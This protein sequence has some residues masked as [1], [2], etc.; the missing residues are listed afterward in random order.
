MPVHAQTL[1]NGDPIGNNYLKK[2]KCYL[3]HQRTKLLMC[4]Q[5]NYILKPVFQTFR[6][7]RCPV[8]PLNWHM[9]WKERARV[10]CKQLE[11]DCTNRNNCE[12]VLNSGLVIHVRT[13]GLI[14]LFSSFIGKSSF[15]IM[16][17]GECVI[18]L[19]IIKLIYWVNLNLYTLN[20]H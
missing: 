9:Y 18:I 10:P 8:V 11:I 7:R 17:I 19:S 16:I 5:S 14:V 2:S 15:K 1:L 4:R 20:L 6:L 3:C 12:A 13:F